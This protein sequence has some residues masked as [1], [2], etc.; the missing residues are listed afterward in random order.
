MPDWR[1]ELEV[2]LAG[3]DLSPLQHAEILE[4]LS[5]HL[6]DRYQDLLSR[7]V[8]AA[9]ARG[10][11]L[12]ELQESPTL[13][14]ALAQMEPRAPKPAVPV[15]GQGGEGW[16]GRLAQDLRFGL[17]LL[18]T[19]PGFTLVAA[20]TLALGIGANTAIFSTV[21]AVLLRPL[22][23]PESDRLVTFWGTAPEKR[24]PVVTYPDAMF[25]YFQ[26]HARSFESVAAWTA[27]SVALSGDGEP[28]RV[29]TTWVSRD[30]FK[31]MW[32]TSRS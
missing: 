1:K 29:R 30:F 13:Q 21:H 27:G 4:E 8:Q 9:L 14:G 26:D 11:A 7:G 22:P 3:L 10:T 17:R 18:R 32:Q 12:E 19:R 24:L 20:L 28:E 23:Y 15:G 5:Q 31:V 25:L 6:E 16:L 2:R